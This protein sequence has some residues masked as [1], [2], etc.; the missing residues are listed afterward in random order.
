MKP[1]AVVAE[2]SLA[3]P[4]LA[5]ALIVL[6][7]EVEDGK[8]ANRAIVFPDRLTAKRGGAVDWVILDPL[9]LSKPA[10]KDVRINW[11]DRPQEPR[12]EKDPLEKEARGRK[13]IKGRVKQ[14]AEL[15]TYTY[16]VLLGD[17][18]VVD[19]DLEIVF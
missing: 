18:V 17:E 4:G 10:D 12:K 7:E 13:L 19:P 8:R 2:R 9:G 16:K 3:V 1:K 15:G 5:A 11:I 14:D 6:Y